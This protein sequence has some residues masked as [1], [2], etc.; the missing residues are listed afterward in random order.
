MARCIC[1]FEHVN[2]TVLEAGTVGDADIEVDSHVCAVD[3]EL[4]RFV[5]RPP[6]SVPLVLLGDI[7]VRFEVWIDSHE[8]SSIRVA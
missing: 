4:F 1:P 5:D 2:G 6:D 3:S 8:I 7:A